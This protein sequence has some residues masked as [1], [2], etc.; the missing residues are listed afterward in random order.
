MWPQAGKA[1][2]VPAFHEALF[3]ERAG[4]RAVL[5]VGGF[6]NLSLIEP[7]KPVAGFD[8]GPGMYCWTP[9]F[10]SSVATTLIATVNGLPA[11]KSSLC[12]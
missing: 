1:P 11:E 12:C 5:N 2:L 3:E 7:G 4:N 9:G 10:I 6:S 8:C